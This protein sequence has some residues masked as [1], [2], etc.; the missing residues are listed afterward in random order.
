MD[1]YVNGNLPAILAFVASR[2]SSAEPIA[3]TCAERRRLNEEIGCLTATPLRLVNCLPLI[4]LLPRSVT[5]F[6]GNELREKRSDS[7]VWII[8]SILLYSRINFIIH[9]NLII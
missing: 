6:A 8:V 2:L 3:C 5:G 9:I 4:Q 7:N 1:L